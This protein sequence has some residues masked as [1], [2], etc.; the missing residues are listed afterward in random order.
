LNHQSFAGIGKA[1]LALLRKP[2]PA[3]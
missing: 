2:A 3:A 1:L